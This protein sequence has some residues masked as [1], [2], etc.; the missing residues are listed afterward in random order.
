M[1][2][3][4]RRIRVAR[5]VRSPASIK[6]KSIG[7]QQARETI[8]RALGEQLNAL[9]SNSRAFMAD[10]GAGFH[11]DLPPAAFHIAR[12]LH[13]FGAAKVSRV[14]EAVAMDRS[15]T[16]RLTARLIDLGLVEGRPDPADGRGVVLELTDL[17]RKSIERAITRK[18]D[19]FRQKIEP[20]SDTDLELFAA[21]LCR[22]NDLP[23]RR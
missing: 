13:A 7:K 4:Q 12:W 5:Q 17:G 16:S 9:L 22:F 1:G 11:P 8:V 23:L 15:A 19:V 21:L 14:A 6:K 2:S 18:G 20:W 10:A 3:Y